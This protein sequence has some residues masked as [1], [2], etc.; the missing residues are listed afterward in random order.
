MHSHAVRSFSASC[1]T[2]AFK[3]SASKA[4]CRNKVLVW[5]KADCSKY[6]HWT[7]GAEREEK[8]R[9]NAS[10]LHWTG[11]KKRRWLINYPSVFSPLSHIYAEHFFCVCAHMQGKRNNMPRK[12][13]TIAWAVYISSHMGKEYVYTRYHKRKKERRVE[14]KSRLNPML[15]G[16]SEKPRTSMGSCLYGMRIFSRLIS[17]FQYRSY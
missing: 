12:L 6:E 9:K 4:S 16:I 5:T 8:V 15:C 17:W 7:T 14:G 2:S 11:W 3:K 13:A 10:L 1:F